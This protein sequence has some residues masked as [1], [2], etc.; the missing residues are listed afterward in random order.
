MPRLFT[1]IRLPPAIMDGL[2]DTMEALEHA[3]WLADHPGR[4]YAEYNLDKALM[5][6]N[7]AQAR[8]A[9]LTAAELSLKLGDRDAAR[10]GLE[11]FQRGARDDADADILA[12]DGLGV[13]A[14][15]VFADVLV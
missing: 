11:A 2:L 10:R 4:A 1:A 12:R 14:G 7:V 13:L 5:P 3:R 9:Q 6:F 15:A 8:L